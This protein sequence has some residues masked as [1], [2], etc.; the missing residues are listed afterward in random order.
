MS[1][2]TAAE[3]LRRLLAIVP[4]LSA[5]SPVGV[6]EV[7]ERF[8]IDRRTLLADLEV[9]PYVGVP[10]YTPDTMIGVDIDDDHISVILAEP[11]DRP[12]RITPAQALALIAAGHHIPQLPG[13]DETDPLPRALTKLAQALD[14]DPEQVHID[15]GGGEER[16]HAS[17]LAAIT[18][19]R[20]VEIDHYSYGRDE[21]STRRVD[22]YQ[23]V[24]EEGNL[25]LLGWCHRSE[26]TRFFRL[27]R[28]AEV[29]V[30][31]EPARPP[32]GEVPWHRLRPPSD[33]P[34][35]T[36]ELSPAARWVAERYPHEGV[37]ELDDG[38][39]RVTLAVAA[40]AWLE[41]LL[42]SLGPDARVVDG[43]SH[44][45]E[46]GH[47]AAARILARYGEA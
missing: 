9:L 12:L 21:R 28:I 23:V 34:R 18:Q 17:L 36:L 2:P 3:R 6:E 5:H 27:D 30:L 22:P 47:R 10:P 26:D 4:W 35:V 46:A 7:C 1:R 20:Q 33:A 8:D 31:D 14:V 44:L 40:P 38:R 25:Y 15:L 29:T 13:V 11:F 24:A 16:V 32:E 37:D 39:L 42:V 41:R 45:R 43:P 19:G